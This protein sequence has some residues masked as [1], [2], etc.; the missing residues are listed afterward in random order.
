MPR[1]GGGTD[2][3][4]DTFVLLKNVVVVSVVDVS[5]YVVEERLVVVVVLVSPC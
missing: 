2:T 4:V 1:P 5:V 3:F